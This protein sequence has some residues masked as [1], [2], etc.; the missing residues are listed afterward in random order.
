MAE[1]IV[2]SNAEDVPVGGGET[3]GAERTTSRRHL[4]TI[5]AAAVAGAAAAELLSAP[6]A[7]AATG[8][9]MLIGNSNS[10][11]TAS[12]V[13]GLT[14]AFSL[15]D[16]G[17]GSSRSALLADQTNVST[18][19]RYGIQGISHGGYPTN[20]P[21][22]GAGVQGQ[23][24]NG[25]PGLMGVAGAGGPQLYLEPSST[26]SPGV[27]YPGAG[28]FMVVA[29]GDLYY[30]DAVQWNAVRSVI[31]LATPVRIIN[32]TNG[33][34]GITGPLT[35]SATVHTSSVLAG[36]HGIPSNAV[37]MVGNF[38]ISGVNGALLN[39]YGVATIFPAGVST[40]S[41][42]NINAGSG[43][44]AIS[45]T[46]TVAFGTGG[47]AGKVAIVWNGGGPVP[48]AHAFFDVSAYIV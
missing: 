7:D 46:V 20:P 34:G 30:R 35:P 9:N 39:G 27:F 21:A 5:G 36:T 18:N 32:T 40:P 48:K 13:T 33:T 47:N 19:V 3:T 2:P 23:G 42:A 43:C 37:G 15:I 28:Y 17:G 41:T 6:A 38:A 24:L 44:F 31:P 11:T 26:T 22:L 14:G 25:A 29:D 12:D 16:G 1:E 8:G 4:F 45:N 10:V